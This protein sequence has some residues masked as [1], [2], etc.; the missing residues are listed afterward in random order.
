MMFKPDVAL[1]T[2]IIVFWIES[3]ISW[4]VWVVFAVQDKQSNERWSLTAVAIAQ[5][6]LWVLLASFPTTWEAILRTFII[7]LW[8]W[9]IIK[10]ILITIN[11]FKF[12]E[13]KFRN[14]WWVLFAWIIL[15]L[16]GLFITTNSLLTL[17]VINGIIGLWMTLTGITMIILALQVKKDVK[18][19][20][21]ELEEALENGEN[22]EIEI[23][24][25]KR[26]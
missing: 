21:D 12:K 16:I 22:I 14:R 5:I 8:V 1:E 23:T 6:L 26:Y 18:E 20:R 10:W 19:V 15:I 3:I 7:L 2:L 13:L 4:I 17:F 24:K 25:V 9:A 11:S